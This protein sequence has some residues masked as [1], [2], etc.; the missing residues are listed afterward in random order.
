MVRGDTNQ[1]VAEHW[2]LASDPC[3]YKYSSASYYEMND[4]SFSFLKDLREE[5]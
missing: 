5:F 3:R 2:Q 4:A 1:G